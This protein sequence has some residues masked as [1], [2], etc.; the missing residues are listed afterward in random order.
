VALSPLPVEDSVMDLLGRSLVTSADMPAYRDLMERVLPANTALK[1]AI[2]QRFKLDALVFPYNPT[3][4]TPISNPAYK[5][6]D[7]K[8]VASRIP[9]PSTLAGYSSIGSPGIVVP[10]GFGSQGLPMAISFMGQPYEEGKII[11]YAYDYE[12]ET[13]LR[14]PS[15]LVPPLPGEVI[16]L[17]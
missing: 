8:F 9:A 16:R 1:R 7:P 6:D 10:M 14:R 5:R 12:Q 17:R 15:P 11:G 2:F 4:A 13:R 3:F